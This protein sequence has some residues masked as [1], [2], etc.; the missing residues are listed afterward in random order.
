MQVKNPMQRLTQLL[1]ILFLALTGSRQSIASDKPNVLFVAVDD[2]TCSLGCYGHPFARTPSIDSLA[3]Q[4]V[5]FDRAYCQIPLCNPSR[6]SVMTGMRPDEIRVYDLDRHFREQVP[7]LI[8]LPQLFRRNGWTVGRVGKLY[9]YDVPAGIGTNGLDD[10]P[11]WDFVINPKGRDV[12][13]Q[14][15]ITNPTPQ[16]PV[17]AALSWLEADG[18]DVEQTDGLIASEALQFLANVGDE[19]FFLGVG[20]FRPHTP[21][22]APR[23]Y[24]ELYP[25]DKL[26]LPTSPPGDRDDIPRFA[27]AHNN[28]TPNYGLDT[29]TCLTALQAYLATVSFVDAQVGRLIEGLDSLGLADN[30]IVVL[31]SDHGYHLGEHNGIWQKRTLFEQSARSPLIIYAP[32]AILR[33]TGIR[34]SKTSDGRNRIERVVSGVA[35]SGN[36]HSCERIV[37]FVDI[38]PTVAE[39]C[40][41]DITSTLAGRSLVPLLREPQTAWN[42]AAFTQILR[43]GAGKP[44][45]GRTIRT[46]RWRYTE[47]DEG[48]EGTELYDHWN[49]PDEF[50]NLATDRRFT[51]VI[52]G[53]RKQF[54][55][56]AEG[57]APKTPVNP[58]RL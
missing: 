44:V 31:W 29:D 15:L 45:M 21:Y 58:A 32:D 25:L 5:R 48:R 41:L 20:F 43:P 9:H 38:Y 55:N 54:A 50:T 10:P 28:P 39:L 30:T 1:T 47:W 35:A 40:G 3:A 4:G 23:K 7:S 56:T 51:P 11:S 49:D 17:S 57:V 26:A 8:T 19:P 46:N 34:T 13:D 37:E 18:E 36:G 6:A 16:R 27:F 53:L 2:L 24:F 14:N 33:D 12:A 52:T 22:V 42:H